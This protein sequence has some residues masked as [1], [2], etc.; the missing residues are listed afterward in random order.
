MLQGSDNGSELK[1][2]S[3]VEPK[4]WW[5]TYRFLADYAAYQQGIRPTLK[6]AENATSKLLRGGK[7]VTT[8]SFYLRNIIQFLGY[9]NDTPPR[10]CRLRRNEI[11][12]VIRAVQ[13]AVKNLAR[14]IVTHQLNVKAKK[15][16]NIVP[17]ESLRRCQEQ[18]RVV[19]PEL[20]TRMED[21]GCDNIRDD[22]YGYISALSS[23]SMDTG[24]EY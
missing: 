7:E 13:M 12:G 5:L 11:H 21:E 6:H 10:A 3:Q 24:R 2:P 18:A 15:M 22:F 8:T 16:A 19:I 9:L 20:L 23:P 14:P 4:T 1:I 17:R